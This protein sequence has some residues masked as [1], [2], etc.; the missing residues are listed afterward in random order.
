MQYH[1]EISNET[2]HEDTAGL[3]KGPLAS[4][5]PGNHKGTSHHAYSQE[6][7]IIPFK[8]LPV[9]NKHTSC[10]LKENTIWFL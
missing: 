7:E 8:F 10:F 9:S 5:S 6:I 2:A 3:D 1:T 4:I